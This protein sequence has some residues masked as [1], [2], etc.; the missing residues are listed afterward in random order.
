MNCPYKFTAAWYRHV[1]GGHRAEARTWQCGIKRVC[2]KKYVCGLSVWH[3]F[4]SVFS[5]HPSDIMLY[6][7]NFISH[8]NMCRCPISSMLRVCSCGIATV[9]KDEASPHRVYCVYTCGFSYKCGCSAD[10]YE[11]VVAWERMCIM[12]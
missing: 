8:G 1:Y 6:L 3:I 11:E 4:V 12:T 2:W 10:M 9:I 5:A 7:I